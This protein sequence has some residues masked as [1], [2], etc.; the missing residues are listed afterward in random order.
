M[1]P[2]GARKQMH[3]KLLTSLIGRLNKS[4]LKQIEASMRPRVDGIKVYSH[5]QPGAKCLTVLN[6]VGKD[7]LH[8]DLLLCGKCNKLFL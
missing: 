4:I 2:D 6:T 7:Q 3:A 1:K 5:F 8:G